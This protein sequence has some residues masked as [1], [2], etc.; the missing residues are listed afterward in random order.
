MQKQQEL[1]LQKSE[2]AQLQQQLMK[3]SGTFF[4]HD[5]Q[6]F[7]TPNMEGPNFQLGITACQNNFMFV[8]KIHVLPKMH[9][10]QKFFPEEFAS[11]LLGRY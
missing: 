11:V 4:L 2:C 5:L 1:S 3:V 9:V 10:F 6:G 7:G 8:T